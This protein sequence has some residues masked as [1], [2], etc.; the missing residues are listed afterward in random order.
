[1][2]ESSQPARL[3]PSFIII[4][5][6]RAGTT[7]LYS[8]LAEHPLIAPAALKEVH[9]FDVHFAKGTGWYWGQFPASPAAGAITG[10]ASPYYLFHPLAPQRIAELLPEVKLITLLRNPIDRALSHHQHESRRGKETLPFGEALAAE[11]ARLRGEAERIVREPGYRS[12]AHQW[13]SYRSRGC[14]MDQLEQWL[15]HF[16]RENFLT[17]LSERFYAD[18][19]TALRQVTDFLGLP[20]LPPQ[21]AA[22]F[23]KHNLASYEEMDPT[24]RQQLG[25]FYRPHNARLAEFLGEDPGWD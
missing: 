19:S 22:S 7:S 14:Y 16:P 6:Q 9:F 2:S 4:G 11:P 20:S 8:Y 21:Q 1:V 24:L 25:E 23:E 18:P 13:H 5:A 12:T 17:L 3:K 10:E 15:P